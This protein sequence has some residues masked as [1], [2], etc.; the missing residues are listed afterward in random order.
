MSV[1]IGTVDHLSD[2]VIDCIFSIVCDIKMSFHNR[3]LNM[4][5]NVGWSPHYWL[6][7]CSHIFVLEMYR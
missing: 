2:T 1:E 5:Q 6:A 7:I 3:T 4:H